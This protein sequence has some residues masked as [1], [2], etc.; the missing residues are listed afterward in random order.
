LTLGEGMRRA[1]AD[2]AGVSSL[3]HSNRHTK[4]LQGLALFGPPDYRL[5]L[6]GQNVGEPLLTPAMQFML[7]NLAA[8][9]ALPVPGSTLTLSLQ[10]NPV[11]IAE[12]TYFRVQPSSGQAL[13]L[14]DGGLPLQPAVDLALDPSV[15][16][17]LIRD[18]SFSEIDGIDPVIMGG[19]PISEAQRYSERAYSGGRFDRPGWLNTYA[20]GDG[21]SHLIL[22]SGQW[23]PVGDRQRLID[24]LSLELLARRSG[25]QPA[26]LGG[27]ASNCRLTE[28]IR[29]NVPDGTGIARIEVVLIEDGRFSVH[30]MRP[31]GHR[32]TA[33]FTA[34][35]WSRY[36]IQAVGTDGSV[37]LDTNRGALYIVPDE[38]APCGT[39]CD[40]NSALDD[41][42]VT[43]LADGRAQFLNY[44]PTCRYEVG[45]AAYAVHGTELFNQTLH[46]SA[47]K[48]L[49]TEATTILEVGLPTCAAQVD[50][51]YGSTIADPAPPRYADRL[52][53]SQQVRV[54]QYCSP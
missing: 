17:V 5:R 25:G 14:A 40:I 10:H 51:F 28:R 30:P 6:A 23:S 19:A 45:M 18:G 12:G 35:P 53:N 2:Y 43:F 54:G 33:T 13:L 21:K 34:K 48:L 15:G 24:S 4:T 7:S 42:E 16:G 44:S 31:V 8:P 50:A 39:G 41:L 49:Q 27:P 47:K 38:H 32:W 11:S 37:T 1:L 26:Q 9:A 3:T 46:A 29:V 36:M 52:L 20:G 22:A